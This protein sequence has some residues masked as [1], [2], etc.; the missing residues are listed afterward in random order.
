[1]KNVNWKRLIP[2]GLT[3]AASTAVAGIH[4]K[5]SRIRDDINNYKRSNGCI[6]EIV[7]SRAKSSLLIK[8]LSKTSK[9]EEKKQKGDFLACY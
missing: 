8:E 3:A 2:L 5:N 1:M 7:K 9:N 6:M 4:Q